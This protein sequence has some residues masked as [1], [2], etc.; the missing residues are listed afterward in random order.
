[1]NSH[2]YFFNMFSGKWKN[3]KE[4]TVDS[5]LPYSIIF[6]W[7]YS[8]YI[9]SDFFNVTMSNDDLSE[10]MYYAEQILLF[11]DDIKFTELLIGFIGDKISFS[12]NDNETLFLQIHNLLAAALKF[13]DA[14]EFKSGVEVVKIK[15]TSVLNSI[16]FDILSDFPI[17]TF[18]TLVDYFSEPQ[19]ISYAHKELLKGNYDVLN[20]LKWGTISKMLMDRSCSQL[21]VNIYGPENLHYFLNGN[22]IFLQNYP[23]SCLDLFGTINGIEENGQSIIVRD[24]RLRVKKGDTLFIKPASEKNEFKKFEI[25]NL[26]FLIKE[27]QLPIEIAYPKMDLKILLNT[28]LTKEYRSI[29]IKHKQK[30]KRNLYDADEQNKKKKSSVQILFNNVKNQTY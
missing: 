24:I 21:L 19:I 4:L 20:I 28:E 6:N 9:K 18:R 2:E 8:Y 16:T 3:S 1:M 10:L 17:E 26:F 14:G 15:L 5:I 27:N 7:I 11:K 25:D 23:L 13:G 12:E 22:S 29:Y 30:I